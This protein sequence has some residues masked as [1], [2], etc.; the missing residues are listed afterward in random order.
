MDSSVQPCMDFYKFAC[1][2]YDKHESIRSDRGFQ[3]LNQK[4]RDLLISRGRTLIENEYEDNS[5]FQSDLLVQNHYKSC[6]NT[7]MIESLGL[8]PLKTKLERVGLGNWPILED[9][10]E[11]DKEEGASDVVVVDEWYEIVP[12]LVGEGLE[13]NHL[14]SLYV[15][16]NLINGDVSEILLGQAPLGIPSKYLLNGTDNEEVKSYLHYMVKTAKLFKG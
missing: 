12:K 2:N 9:C 13:F 3:N 11:G 7:T 1:G 8:S 14:F 5:S 15:F 10:Q 16:P 6:M 4:M